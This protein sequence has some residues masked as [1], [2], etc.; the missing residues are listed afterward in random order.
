M[1]SRVALAVICSLII[2]AGVAISGLFDVP[3]TTAA[4]LEEPAYDVTCN[5]FPPEGYLPF[6]QVVGMSME[7][8]DTPGWGDS[9]AIS[10]TSGYT[11]AVKACVP[12]CD[13][14]CCEV[15]VWDALVYDGTDY[16]WR[17]GWIPDDGGYGNGSVVV[18]CLDGS[19]EYFYVEGDG[20]LVTLHVQRAK[21]GAWYE[22]VWMDIVIYPPEG[23]PLAMEWYY[24]LVIT[25]TTD[26]TQPFGPSHNG[27]DFS[28]TEGRPVYAVY[29]GTVATVDCDSTRGFY[30]EV[31]HGTISDTTYLSRYDHLSSV[32][33][34]VGDEVAGGCQIA[35]SGNTG[36]STG[37]HLHLVI[38]QDSTPVDPAPFLDIYP[39]RW[40]C[41]SGGYLVNS[42]FRPGAELAGW[43]TTGALWLSAAPVSPF[44]NEGVVWLNAGGTL[45][46]A[47]SWGLGGQATINV[48]VLNLGADPSTLEIS[49][50]ADAANGYGIPVIPA[51]GAWHTYQISI[52]GTGS[53]ENILLHNSSSAMPLYVDWITI[54]EYIEPCAF[55]PPIETC[56]LENYS[57]DQ[58]STGW[59]SSGATFQDGYVQLAAGGWIAQTFSA[60]LPVES[61]QMLAR[62]TSAGQVDLELFGDP[63]PP[64]DYTYV[65]VGIPVPGG[66]AWQP[67]QV[68]ISGTA[69]ITGTVSLTITNA[70]A[71]A[72]DL[73]DIC[74]LVAGDRPP[75]EDPFTYCT[76]LMPLS[77]NWFDW[78]KL[79]D[80]GGWLRWMLC[81]IEKFVVNLQLAILNAIDVIRILLQV[82][83]DSLTWALDN[84]ACVLTGLLYAWFYGQWAILSSFL[85]DV[86]SWFGLL[87]AFGWILDYL[88]LGFLGDFL[89]LLRD[90]GWDF[91][92]IYNLVTTQGAALLSALNGSAIADL[93]LPDPGDTSN[94]MYPIWLG[95]ALADDAIADTP[96]QYAAVVAMGVLGFRLIL[97][98][99][100]MLTDW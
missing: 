87:L 21:A 88:N 5:W 51:D 85:Q 39:D 17:A 70:A 15:A 20:E 31:D 29:T 50:S 76:H 58:G 1:K 49:Y 60:D 59:T 63:G 35:W 69:E 92:L 2:L 81:V 40:D 19:W 99:I 32:N 34:A 94:I 96:F 72:V 22:Y 47:Q 79:F 36:E 41:R 71:Y 3:M 27:I 80:L 66:N 52:I 86:F 13:T 67:L 9:V 57:L 68:V 100:Q 84:W 73:D 24:P 33:V 48:R 44:V 97:W 30:V 28:V 4:P 6:D 55:G 18:G 8:S 43:T 75:F 95:F 65:G 53:Y 77:G 91:V 46:Q 7:R 23:S 11:Y 98:A 45:R 10:I 90:L 62:S 38:E 14:G 54:G 12:Q 82:V 56:N 25:D 93:G 42:D 83:I 64:G 37:P 61:V 16:L 74:V 26:V 89:R 78:T